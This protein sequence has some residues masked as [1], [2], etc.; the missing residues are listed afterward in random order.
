VEGIG[1]SALLSAS[2]EDAEAR[3]NHIIGKIEARPL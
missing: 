3:F 2:R 1:S